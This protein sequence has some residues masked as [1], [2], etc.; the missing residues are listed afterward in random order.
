MCDV[1][2]AYG[3]RLT[4]KVDVYSYGVVLLEMVTGMR[5][6]STTFADGVC[7][8]TWVQSK[9]YEKWSEVIDPSLMDE[10][11]DGKEHEVYNVLTIALSCVRETPRGRPSMIDVRDSLLSMR[12]GKPISKLSSEDV[13]G[14]DSRT[15]SFTSSSNLL[16]FRTQSWSDNFSSQ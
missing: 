3:E 16:S 8:P 15:N 9:L 10:V 1:E 12:Q 11:K 5:P 14:Y 4:D 7:L 2:Y 6:T 13:G